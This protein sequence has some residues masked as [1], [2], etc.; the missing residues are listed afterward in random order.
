MIYSKDYDYA[1]IGSGSIAWIT[2]LY[3]SNAAKDSS[4]ALISELPRYYSASTAAGAMH[5][6]F[7]E[8]EDDI[9]KSVEERRSFEVALR[10]RKL[11][12]DLFDQ[13]K[14]NSVITA[15][16]TVVYL[17]NKAQSLKITTII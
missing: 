3:L 6:V 17:Q 7:G 11:W 12:K 5:A 2:S 9:S 16:D 8:I 14:L 15:K 1:I 13:Y 4:I 10:S